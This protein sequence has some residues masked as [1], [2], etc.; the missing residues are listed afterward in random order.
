MPNIRARKIP[1][2]KPNPTIFGNSWTETTTSPKSTIPEKKKKTE[3]AD[4]F[5]HQSSSKL[6]EER[7]RY[8]RIIEKINSTTETSIPS[9][10]APSPRF[11]SFGSIDGEVAS[12]QPN[13][14]E[15]Q[16]NENDTIND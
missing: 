11:S 9:L 16:T 5:E 12:S 6:I 10:A 1:K 15:S 8:R 14:S 7:K 13:I 2:T 4:L 3:L